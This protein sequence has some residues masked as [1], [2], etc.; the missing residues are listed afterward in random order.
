VPAIYLKEGYGV[1]VQLLR[2]H[3]PLVLRVFVTKN[4]QVLEVKLMVEVAIY[5][6]AEL[7]QT[8]YFEMQ[9]ID[10]SYPRY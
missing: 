4:S 8:E 6:M 10:S 2:L 9:T 1:E 3:R 5:L 7:R